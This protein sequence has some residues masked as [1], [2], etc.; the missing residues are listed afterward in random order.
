M[1]LNKL[2]YSNFKIYITKKAIFLCYYTNYNSLISYRIM[3]KTL[4]CLMNVI[5]KI[6]SF[7]CFEIHSF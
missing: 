2:F 4:Y 1:K 5:H 7:E 6:F 3:K